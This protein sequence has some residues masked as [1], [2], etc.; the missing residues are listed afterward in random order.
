MLG[1]CKGANFGKPP[2]ERLPK[3]SGLWIFWRRQSWLRASI[4]WSSMLIQR[5]PMKWSWFHRS[6][7]HSQGQ[8]VA[9]SKVHN[10]SFKAHSGGVDSA[11][12]LLKESMPKNVS[13]RAKGTAICNRKIHTHL[14]A[15]Q[16]QWRWGNT[17]VPNLCQNTAMAYLRKKDT[18]QKWGGKMDLNKTQEKTTHFST[19]PTIC[20]L[21]EVVRL[22]V[23][24]SKKFSP[25]EI[26]WF[27]RW[28]DFPT[29]I[30]CCKG[31]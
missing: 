27:L 4:W 1:H 7:N 2:L 31:A 16:W 20:S 17:A 21:H 28:T 29:S 11:W 26:A 3:D 5:Q 14:R 8:F 10:K 6:C 18:W 13:T 9:K 22:P 30:K 19:P 24:I 12:Q 25:L 23:K 15:W